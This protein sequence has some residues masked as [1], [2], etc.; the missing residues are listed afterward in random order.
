[1]MQRNQ[2]C[3]DPRYGFTSRTS[4][5]S[6]GVPSSGQVIPQIGCNGHGTLRRKSVQRTTPTVVESPAS[7]RWIGQSTSDV[8]VENVT[9]TYNTKIGVFKQWVNGEIQLLHTCCRLR[10]AWPL[11]MK[12]F[13]CISQQHCWCNQVTFMCISGRPPVGVV[14]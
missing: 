1:M 9:D 5:C 7:K 11:Y 12:F 13:F 10:A 3:D 2:F 6:A 14:S 8:T 4:G